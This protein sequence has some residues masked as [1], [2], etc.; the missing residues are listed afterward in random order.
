MLRYFAYGTNLNPEVMARKKLRYH[1]R[2]RATLNGFRLRFNKRSMR[3]LLPEHIGFAN[4]VPDEGAHI[5]G[6]LYEMDTALSEELDRVERCPAQYRRCSVTVSTDDEEVECFTYQA[7]A[8]WTSEALIPSRNY[9]NHIL[10][11][12]DLLSPGYRRALETH[13]TYAG[14]CAACHQVRTVLFRKEGGRMFV[15]CPSCLEAKSRWSA[16]RG[17]P[18]SVLD[19]EAVMQHLMRTGKGYGSLQELVSEAV[20]LGLVER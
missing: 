2:R 4:I 12:S 11:G 18:F 5:E 17:R 19:T 9:I 6:A 3:E 1:S 7:L 14:E 13:D 8:E 10:A 20:R 15:L 16:A